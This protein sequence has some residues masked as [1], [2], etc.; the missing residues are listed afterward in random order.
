LPS[1]CPIIG[2][3]AGFV[4]VLL[5]AGPFL[6]EVSGK[7][8]KEQIAATA[9]VIG[10]PRLFLEF[11]TGSVLVVLL[12][13]LWIPLKAIRLFQGDYLASFLLLLGTLLVAAHWRAAR[14][15]ITSKLRGVFAAAFAGLVLLLLATAWFELTFSE[16]WLTAGKWARFP[17][18]LL[19][20]LPYHIAEETLLGPVGRDKRSSRLAL[21]LSLRLITWG[22]L[23]AGVLILHNGEILMGLL[24]LYMAV[25]NLIQR[26]GMDIV[27]TE[28]GSAAA[29]ALFGAIL[30]AG[31]CLVIF[32]LT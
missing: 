18:L 25:F 15:A 26:S 4:G 13:R 9:A 16:A 7:D 24:S 10:T 28:T 20:L 8:V 14:G 27:R 6:R 11:V 29:T 22:A 23:M 5:I 31:F 32:P 30:L 2:T 21:A 17:F 3:L 1:H 12:L 19:T